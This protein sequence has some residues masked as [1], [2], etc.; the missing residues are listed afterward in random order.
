[1][2]GE[3]LAEVR[4]DHGDRQ[5]D[6]AEKL[7][8]VKG[9]VSYWEENRSEPDHATLVQICRLYGC[10][11]DWLLGLTDVDYLATKKLLL[12][13]STLIDQAASEIIREE[14]NRHERENKRNR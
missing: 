11:A 5:K 14:K 7:H 6:L 8:V 13:V 2:I 10:T 9:T 1:M 3:R 4:K 12:R